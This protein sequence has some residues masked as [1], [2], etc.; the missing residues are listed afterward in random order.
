[1]FPNEL[2]ARKDIVYYSHKTHAAGL[3][4]A[5][6]GNLSVRLD[7]DHVLITPSSLRKE[8]MFI[9][10]PIVINMQG[11]LVVGERKP[12]TEHKVHLEAYRQ[13]PDIGAVIHAHP[14]KAI[15]FTIAEVSLDTCMLPEVVVTLGNVPVAPYAAPSTEALPES[16]RELIRQADVLMLARHGSVTVGPDLS[17][18][19]KKLEKLEHNAAIMIY[20]RI[21][22][23]P[24]PFS[25]QQ[26]EELQGL[27]GFYGIKT[28][29]IACAAP[30]ANGSGIASTAPRVATTQ[31]RPGTGPVTVAEATGSPTVARGPYEDDEQQAP[32]Y[33]GSGTGNDIEIDALV[34]EIVAR[35]KKR[36]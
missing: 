18:A 15:A 17:D 28:Q 27:R 9:E 33:R 6:D 14:P 10:A 24:K 8:D 1:M 29:Q 26:L 23:G 31:Y 20:A 7:E 5:T 30:G 35:V 3:V 34:D 25:N 4:S 22:G 19:F 12:S 13:R 16:M 21:L 36:L 2:Q 32:T 11:E